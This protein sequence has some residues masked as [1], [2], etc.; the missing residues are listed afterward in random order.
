MREIQDVWLHDQKR[1]EYED[2]WTE[3]TVFNIIRP[4]SAPGQMWQNGSTWQV[5]Q[6]DRPE[7]IHKDDWHIFEGKRHDWQAEWESHKQII[8]DC[9]AGKEFGKDVKMMCIPAEHI[10]EYQT[11]MEDALKQ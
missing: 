10:P 6:T 11:Y 2:W 1:I 5:Q 9:R 4:Q 8:H 7:W 3:S